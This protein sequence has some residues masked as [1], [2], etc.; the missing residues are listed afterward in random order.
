MK[1]WRDHSRTIV[2]LALGGCICIAAR[3][4]WPDG[5][6]DFD[7]ITLLGGILL[8]FG[9]QGIVDAF[10]RETNRPED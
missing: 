10:T 2:G 9:I 3:L 4:Y 6:P 8:A 5:G 1:L 7:I